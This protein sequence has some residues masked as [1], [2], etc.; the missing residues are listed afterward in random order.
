MPAV[1]WST[2]YFFPLRV[3]CLCLP[4]PWRLGYRVLVLD[5]ENELRDHRMHSA[6]HRTTCSLNLA[7]CVIALAC[8]LLH[9]PSSPFIRPSYSS[10]P[11]VHLL[12]VVPFW[13]SPPALGLVLTNSIVCH[14]FFSPSLCRPRR[15]H[16]ATMTEGTWTSRS[17][18]TWHASVPVGSDE[19]KREREERPLK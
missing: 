14:A 17:C 8:L 15:L 3:P 4:V 9:D 18:Q 11:L 2:R 10:T 1:V 7:R 12:L 13:P 16:A 5:L 6:W 19:A